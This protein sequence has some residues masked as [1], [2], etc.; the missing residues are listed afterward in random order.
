MAEREGFESANKRKPNH[1]H[2]SR[3]HS[4]QSFR[5]SGTRTAGKWQ[6][7]LHCAPKSA[8]LFS[9]STS[10]NRTPSSSVSRSAL[11]EL[12]DIQRHWQPPLALRGK[13]WK[14]ALDP[15]WTHSGHEH[16][17]LLINKSDCRGERNQKS[18]TNSFPSRRTLI[19]A[20]GGG[21]ICTAPQ[22]QSET[23]CLLQ[24]QEPFRP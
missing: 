15:N 11:T 2:G 10:R 17:W 19:V 4:K 5:C 3:W 9:S 6:G 1:L 16:C 14:L 8:L 7:S 20:G 21:F 23:M 13:F 12:I 22:S 24:R 18:A